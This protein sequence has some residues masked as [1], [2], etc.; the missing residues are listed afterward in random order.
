MMPRVEPLEF[1][2]YI[3]LKK[4]AAGGMGEVFLARQERGAGFE[5]YVAIK[6]ILPELSGDDEF[7]KMFLDEARLAARLSHPNVVQ[8]YDLGI[9]GEQFYIAMEF[10]EGRDLRRIMGRLGT[11]NRA[12][13]GAHAIQ[14]IYGAAEGLD[15]AHNLKDAYGAS[16]NIIHR[17][18]SPQNIFVT[19]HGTVKVL[20]FG[21]AKAEARS[22][23]TRTG[24]IK[25]KYPY[26]SPEQVRGDAID[27]R[28]D[29][30]SLGTVLWEVTVGR[31]LFKRDND[32]L[33]LQ[34]VLR[35]D[36]ARPSTLMNRYPPELEAIVMRA[37][38]R[39][40]DERYPTC[41]A[42][43]EDLE[44][45]MGQYGLVLSPQKLGESVRRTFADEPGTVQEIL[46]QLKEKPQS[47]SL[48]GGEH[49]PR[50]GASESIPTSE[51]REP[52]DP[53]GPSREIA[54]IDR[55]RRVTEEDSR[56]SPSVF[57]SAK[58]VAE[59]WDSEISRPPPRVA[60]VQRPPTSTDSRTTDAVASTLPPLDRD[61]HRRDDS[62]PQGGDA[63]EAVEPQGRAEGKPARVEERPPEPR[64]PEPEEGR[65]S[66]APG[67]DDT[68]DERRPA[69]TGPEEESP[70]EESRQGAEASDGGGASDGPSDVRSVIEAGMAL[71]RAWAPEVSVSSTET[72]LQVISS[73]PTVITKQVPADVPAPLP[74]T[75]LE[76]I[77]GPAL[78]EAD[79]TVVA[80]TLLDGEP[81]PEVA[82]HEQPPEVQGA[83]PAEPDDAELASPSPDPF[84]VAAPGLKP[85][86]HEAIEVPP[87]TTEAVTETP[88]PDR[89]ASAR[90]RRRVLGVIAL[91]CLAFLIP[92]GVTILVAGL[93]RGPAA[94]RASASA[95]RTKGPPDAEPED[96]IATSVAAP[97]GVSHDA[98]P[99]V[100][101]DLAPLEAGEA[102]GPPADDAEP[103]R[104]DGPG[105]HVTISTDPERLEVIVDGRRLGTSP[106]RASLAP[107]SHQ[108]H[109][110]GALHGID[111][112]TSI[113][114]QEGH[115]SSER[116]QVPRGV[117]A[118][119]VRPYAEVYIDSRGLGLTPMPPVTLYAGRH[120]V[121]LVNDALG[122][123]V[124][125][126]VTVRSG[127]RTEI[128]V[129]L[130]SAP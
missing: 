52:T 108:V 43:Q 121:R 62:I 29:V 14:I 90:K 20:D 92:F 37:L 17:D 31:R 119:R 27:H 120:R 118:L 99:S 73:V 55:A 6:R 48:L 42:L 98:A 91:L 129:D 77:G 38:A 71:G 18:V 82:E 15:Y 9:C 126:T 125:R 12:L 114:V 110:L 74:P 70:D 39:D 28:S 47:Q 79:T 88:L 40:P 2:D 21:I 19:F 22:V 16:L 3:L 80:E 57:P 34:A 105:V 117:L 24:G 111:F 50:D 49:S 75:V 95:S 58:P 85:P 101:A 33:T 109:L 128:D 94:P 68:L 103:Q 115:R 53:S 10:L 44:H 59:D 54:V 7:I 81:T 36:V 61:L 35:C 116:I 102:D 66:V 72:L 89:E 113:V 41:H 4:L 46:D 86:R 124:V 106:V 93:G 123:S 25:G 78:G 32:L 8:I 45:F 84:S 107:G 51:D 30:F 60:V 97:N 100:E 56:P 104:A 65:Q 112:G 63:A 127:Q 5:R 13:P 87:E 23:R 64:H 83:A 1:G 11:Y 76:L 67:P 130:T 69:E 122:R 26:L 96:G